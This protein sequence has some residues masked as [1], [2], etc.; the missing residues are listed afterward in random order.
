MVAAVTLRPVPSLRQFSVLIMMASTQFR[1]VMVL[2]QRR[3]FH[4]FLMQVLTPPCSR[5][6]ELSK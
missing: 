6:Q 3:M 4:K 5:P 2:L 1:M